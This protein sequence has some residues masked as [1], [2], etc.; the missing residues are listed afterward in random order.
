MGRSI[1]DY[2]GN[3]DTL[4]AVI[5]GAVLATGGAIVA[6]IIKE[7]AGRAHRQ[8][9]A[10][11]FFGEIL[12]SIDQVLDVAI[13]SQS[14]GDRWGSITRRLFRA[15]RD[16]AGVYERNRERLFEIQDMNLRF[17]IHEH[18]L[19]K[20]IAIVAVL[21]YCAEA[22]EAGTMREAQN[23][24]TGDQRKALEAELA[25]RREAAL[26]A[27]LEERAK[28]R[29]ITLQLEKLAKVKFGDLGDRPAPRAPSSAP[30]ITPEIL[31]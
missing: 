3:L 16:E 14:I 18:F 10:A 2:V 8:R 17:R 4:L 19:R 11:R 24:L 29:S 25:D 13:G 23:D 26:A 28:T 21:E 6:D 5:V 9:D 27:I 22:E 7:R 12:T 20:S 30:E 31:T 15:A 1:F